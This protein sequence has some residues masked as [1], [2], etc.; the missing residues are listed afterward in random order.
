M[1]SKILAVLLSFAMVV[2]A[3]STH[4]QT[5]YATVRGHVTDARGS[6]VPHATLR[7]ILEDTGEQ[8]EIPSGAAGE[9]TFPVLSPGNYRFEVQKEGY[10]THVLTGVSLSI[11]QNVRL[12]F[13]LE[14]GGPED[15]VVT[16]YSDSSMIE[17][18]AANTG[19]VIENAQIVNLPLDKRD[20][21]R[22][23]LLLPGTAPAAQGSPG[24]A[25]DEFAVNVNGAREDSNNFILDGVFNN[26]PKLNS[27]A[28]NPP[29]DAIQEF[30][31][32]TGTY[33]AGFGRSGGA[34]VNIAL[35]SGTN[36]LH[37][38]V[39]E[40]FQ[41]AALNAQNYFAIADEGK[42]RFQHNQYGFS[43][44]GPVL[45]NRTFFF[46]DYEGRRERKGITLATNVPTELEREGDFSG[47]LLP[48]PVDPFT[49]L[50][51][52]NGIIPFYYINEVG[53][54]VA[55]LYPHPNRDVPGQNYV[56]SP[57]KRRREDRFDLR[58]DHSISQAS[59]LI[60]RF[61]FT[62]YDVY[63]PFSGDAFA[64]VPGFGS[65]IARRAQNFMLGS[66]HTF[67]PSL[68]NQ[69]RFSFNRVAFGAFQETRDQSLN[70]TVGIPA[71]NPDPRDDGLSFLRVT[72]FSPLGDEYNNPNH[73]VTNVFQAVDTLHFSTGRH[74]IKAGVELR[75]LQ[76]NA[77]RD[78]Q[79][80]GFMN[81]TGLIAGN[82]LAD[83]LLGLPTVTGGA[84]VDNPQYLRAVSWSFFLH[85]SY[86][87]RHDV[88]LQLGLRYE[89]NSAPVDRYDRAT[90]FDPGMQSLVPVG[91][92]GIPRGVY[93]P[94]G[95]NWAPR[96]GL[97]WSLDRANTLLVH[98]GYGIFYDQSSLAP[99]EGLYFNLPY[100]DFRFYFPS[101]AYPLL[102][103]NNPFP[104]D[105]PFASPSTALG[106]DPNLRTPYFQQWNLTLEK[107]LGLKTLL[108]LAYV[109]S[110]GS[111]ILSARDIN[112]PA[113]GAEMPNLRPLPQFADIIYLESGGS[114]SYHSFQARLQQRLQD[115]FSA[116]FSYTYGKSLDTS[117]TFFASAGDSNF[118]QNSRNFSAEKGRSNFDVR[119]RFSVGY[120]YDLPV[121]PGHA[122][123]PQKH[124]LSALL[125][126]WSTYGTIT[127]QSGR[128][129]TVALLPEIDNSNT[130]FQSLGFGG[131]N[132]RPD[133][134]DNGALEDPGAAMW[135]DVDAFVP[136]TFGN[137]GN[138]GRNILDGPGF[139][140][141][142]I[143]LIKNTTI[144]EDV[145]F[146]FRAEFLNAFNH[147]NFDLPDSFW[148]SS[149]FGSINSAGDP[150]RIQFGAKIIF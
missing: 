90:T 6:V 129:F 150:R 109:G 24:S 8:N 26:D 133:R 66:D 5:L 122:F 21:L 102:L 54:A 83:L 106:F 124:A 38:T 31:I 105:Y 119:H 121:G 81:F 39:Y 55:D 50:P 115:G 86:R 127:L 61:S 47:S 80:R 32:L 135:F 108:E 15:A 41:N 35:K 48:A 71:L 97:A 98:A 110:K 73:S 36:D 22:L 30:E 9:F 13:V 107:Q 34:Q 40:F 140:E 68:I 116:L 69:A 103:I 85:D 128:P 145:R 3:V 1:K 72:G 65:N 118:P 74:L 144:R 143:S 28:I 19:M 62:D 84:R 94:D 18:D 57:I 87:I 131:A 45:R 138:S 58:L 51:F 148:G 146:Q 126:G 130:G 132:N 17:P 149:T 91:Q 10:R 123:A 101:E 147:V 113:P 134:I 139:K 82:S 88:T 76:Q 53:R 142:S 7:A 14:I 64:R 78:V 46:G 27:F 59:K 63:D 117:S 49:G 96:I 112:Q 29:V 89:Y 120:S 77:Y 16:V 111:K 56:S 33:D 25:R 125:S 137:F 95:N 44:G 37:G 67:S 141:F 43:L 2:P 92:N 100:Y 75:R 114:S 79:A 104:E 11:G 99:G 93:L 52:E 70:Q 4:S 20:F 23:S 60:S 136:A 12:D 42:P